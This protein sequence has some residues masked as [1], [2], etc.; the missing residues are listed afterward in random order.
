M[1]GT[2]SDFSWDQKNQGGNGN[3]FE[4]CEIMMSTLSNVENHKSVSTSDVC[5]RCSNSADGSVCSSV[6]LLIF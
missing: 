5:T 3:I 6:N 2:D 1:I 4:F